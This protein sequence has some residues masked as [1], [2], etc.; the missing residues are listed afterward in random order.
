[1]AGINNF[2]NGNYCLLYPLAKNSQNEN[3]ECFTLIIA[4]TKKL[5]KYLKHI[6][7][8]TALSW[9]NV[10]RNKTRSIVVLV[11]IVLGTVAGV[12]VA[13]IMNGW[14]AQR[15][16]SAIYTEMGHLKIQNPSFLINEETQFSISNYDN[17]VSYLKNSKE[18]KAFSS[19]SKIMAVATTARGNTG[20]ILKGIDVENE[21]AVS[22]VYTRIL[23]NSGTFFKSKSRLPQV[24]ISNKTAE[25]LRIKNF[26]VT[27]VV[28]DSLKKLNV[29]DETIGKLE[30][31]IDKRF[32]TKKKF[33]SRIK[34]LWSNKEIRKY[35]PKLIS[36]A[37]YF[38]PRAKIVFN[39]T[40]TDGQIGSQRFQVCGVFKTSNTMFDQTSAYVKKEELYGVTGLSEN[41]VHEISI[42]SESTDFNAIN[43][44]KKTLEKE[45]PDQN[46]MTWKELAPDAGMM[47]DF[48]EIYYYIIMGIIFFA[49]AF[50]IINTMLM[51][52]LERIKEL[53]MLMAIGMKKTQVFTMIMLETIFL[54]LSGSVVGMILGGALIAITS[55]TGLNFS[56][57]AEGFEAIGFAAKVYPNIELSFFF[58]VTLL[59]IV[60]AILASLIPARKALKLKPIEALRME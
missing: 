30:T 14:V 41:Q 12:F 42:I 18:V 51:S 8:I 6:K 58:G 54:T 38:Q 49:L 44:F 13:G 57:V 56:S 4:I 27:N 19:R 60:V 5:I 25:M 34:E 37:T 33:E 7:M 9:K 20:V 22:D 17:I 36:A 52:I 2:T 24:V 10:W 29:P 3:N 48:M 26:R 35:G 15:I 43:S 23:P 45:F 28:N 39:Y 16:D 1:M 59:V 53:G 31:I 55:K 40:R 46:I 11:A 47:A 32:L 21:K 50:G